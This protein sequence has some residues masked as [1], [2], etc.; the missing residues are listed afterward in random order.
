MYV[1]ISRSIWPSEFRFFQQ[2]ELD[3]NMEANPCY[4]L[5]LLGDS[6]VGKTS[7]IS[8]RFS[9][10]FSDQTSMTVGVS[11]FTIEEEI[12]DHLVILKVWDTAGQEQYNSLIPMFSRNS[13]VCVFILDITS[14]ESFFHLKDWNERLSQSESDVIKI[15]AINKT[16]LCQD[17]FE[18]ELDKDMKKQI[19]AYKDVVYVSAMNGSGIHELFELAA[20]RL[21]EHE[22]IIADD[23]KDIQIGDKAKKKK[24][25]VVENRINKNIS[26]IIV[27]MI[28]FHIIKQ[29]DK[30]TKVK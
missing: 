30:F 8:R 22:P 28:L 25:I 23:K 20:H 18:L 26:I 11:Y 3:F 21:F 6:G 7:I 16:D 14:K 29:V 5:I 24:K 4:K 12:N 15:V 17:D 19:S 10:I 9:D 2:S 1:H 27:C 13:D